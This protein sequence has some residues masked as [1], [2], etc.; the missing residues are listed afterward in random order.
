MICFIAA[1]E[2]T[3][4]VMLKGDAVH[5]SCKTKCTTHQPVRWYHNN[6][7]VKSDYIK[8][9]LTQQNG[10]VVM[11]VRDTDAGIYE[12]REDDVV[13]SRHHVKLPGN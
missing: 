2:N 4:N 8:W 5:L 7:L 9:I 13:L 1:G 12:C 11:Q 3:V 10:L 6:T